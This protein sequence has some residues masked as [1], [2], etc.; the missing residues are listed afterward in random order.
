MVS[1][2]GIKKGL[3]DMNK[4]LLSTLAKWAAILSFLLYA[5]DFLNLN[6]FKPKVVNYEESVFI[7][8]ADRQT[9]EHPVSRKKH[10]NTKSK[11]NRKVINIKTAMDL[12]LGEILLIPFKTHDKGDYLEYTIKM[13]YPIGY[14]FIYAIF[15]IIFS[16]SVLWGWACIIMILEELFY[17]FINYLGIKKS[18]E[19]NVS[20]DIILISIFSIF[21]SWYF[22]TL[23]GI[24]NLF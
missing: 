6:P 20:L 5:I 18:Y 7:E 19:H 21:F 11:S 3:I 4:N 16:F 12:S 13:K 10:P 24:I 22:L 17:I 23:R 15:S 2:T 9:I 14:Y 1:K 8:K